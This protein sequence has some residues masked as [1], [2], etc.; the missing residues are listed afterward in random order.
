MA[1]RILLVEDDRALGVGLRDRLAH[2]G[3]EVA[4]AQDG[5]TGFDLAR[6]GEYDLLILDVMLP[7]KSGFDI[8]RDLRARGVHTMILLL[9]ARGE[10]LDIVLGL[11]LGADDYLTKPF[12]VHELV[13]RVEALIRRVRPRLAPALLADGLEVDWNSLE[14]KRDGAV[15]TLSAMEFRLLRY[16]VSRTGAV[17]SR[18]ELLREVWNQ[19]ETAYTR[20]VDVH[21]ASLR[22]KIEANARNPS[23]I[24]T[25]AGFGYRWM[26]S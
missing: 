18:E 22:R 26:G 19:S 5:Q 20:T 1:S 12:D 8:C 24:V 21:I 16:L 13:A 2:E 17:V 3:F 9:T 25:V 14:V 6:S 10:S 15:I 11:K 7:G 4:L 23:L